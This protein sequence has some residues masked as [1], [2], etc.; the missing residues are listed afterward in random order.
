MEGWKL[1]VENDHLSGVIDA[2]QFLYQVEQVQL[3]EEPLSKL[4]VK[5]GDTVLVVGAGNVAIDAART[6]LRLKANV[7]SYNR[8]G[9]KEYEM[10]PFGI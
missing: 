5:P 4:P 6:A 1:G 9:R 7:K 3:G 8:R 2:A 10:S